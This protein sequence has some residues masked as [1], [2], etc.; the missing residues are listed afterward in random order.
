[1]LNRFSASPRLRLVRQARRGSGARNL[2]RPA[3][4]RH[5]HERTEVRAP[6]GAPDDL[7]F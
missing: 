6:I 1:M 3:R 2:F 4:M 7:K 5:R